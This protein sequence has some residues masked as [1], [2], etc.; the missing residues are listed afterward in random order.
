M[1][2]GAEP[3]ATR[4]SAGLHPAL[5]GR[6]WVASAL[7]VVLQAGVFTALGHGAARAVGL[8]LS[9]LWVLG[10]GV[11]GFT[12]L[13]AR[14]RHVGR[15]QRAP[16]EALVTAVAALRPEATVRRSRG[17]PVLEDHHEG[18]W[19]ALH[20]ESVGLAPLRVGVTV[21]GWPPVAVWLAAGLPED[22]P[23]ATAR[24][25]TLKRRFVA[26]GWPA[27]ADPRLM[28]LSPD[29]EPVAEWLAEPGA[30]ERAESLLL[31]NAPCAATLELFGD[32]GRWDTR[33]TDRVDPARVA[34]VVAALVAWLPAEPPPAP[35]ELAE[36]E[37]AEG[38][39]ADG[40]RS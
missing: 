37:G 8:T 40:A 35:D 21:A 15:S 16:A 17:L 19:F 3:P 26:V 33:L 32:T 30:L 4:G 1:R 24:R 2:A 18:R 11:L 25:L 34:E 36:A 14:V 31:A 28:G 9:P 39:A 22:G 23:E 29:P 12:L 13:E 6:G 20:F 10:A 27:G 5:R 7:G 38:G